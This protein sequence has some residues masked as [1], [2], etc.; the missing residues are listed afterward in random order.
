MTL[1]VNHPAD[2]SGNSPTSHPTKKR[3]VPLVPI[4]AAVVTAA[5]LVIVSFTPGSSDPGYPPTGP[6]TQ[7]NT[8][9]GPNVGIAPDVVN[10]QVGLPSQLNRGPNADLAPDQVNP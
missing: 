6:G 2:H 7:M 5:V 1:T 9:Q 10:N 4:L 8:N 3:H